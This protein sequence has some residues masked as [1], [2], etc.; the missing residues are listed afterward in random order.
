MTSP[1]LLFLLRS[2]RYPRADAF[3]IDDPAQLQA[4][5]VWLENVKI[6]RYPIDGR[7]Q[8]QSAVSAAWQAALQQYLSDLEC[9][10]QLQ[11]GNHSAVLQWLLTHAGPV[12]CGGNRTVAADIP[13]G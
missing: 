1:L 10:V 12:G 3:N 5:V 7:Q 8:L 4:A 11:H 13:A 6:R 9:P 2:L